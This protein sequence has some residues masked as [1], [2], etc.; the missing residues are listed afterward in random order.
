MEYTSPLHSWLRA[1][2]NNFV[3]S[4]DNIMNT[5]M[6][7]RTSTPI[8]VLIFSFYVLSKMESVQSRPNDG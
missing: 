7:Y 8:N 5:N 3:C 4:S 6:Q 2:D 1:E